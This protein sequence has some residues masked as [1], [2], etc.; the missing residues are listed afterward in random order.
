MFKWGIHFKFFLKFYLEVN[1]TEVI[2]YALPS[3][4][5][6]YSCP[7]KIFLG[8]SK[9]LNMNLYRVATLFEGFGEVSEFELNV[10]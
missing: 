8:N 9:I 4:R 10:E 6:L 5:Q 7:K 1:C 3:M 2:K